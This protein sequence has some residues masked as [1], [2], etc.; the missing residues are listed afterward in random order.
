MDSL[1]LIQNS[2]FTLY[3]DNEVRYNVTPLMVAAYNKKI[4]IINYLLRAKDIDIHA[5]DSTNRTILNYCIESELG[6]Y[7]I[8]ALSKALKENK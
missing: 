6:V 7:Y 3:T 8:G 2:K 1:T 5:K 4:S